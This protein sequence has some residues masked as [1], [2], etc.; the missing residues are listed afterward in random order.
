VSDSLVDVTAFEAKTR[1]SELLRETGAR[2]V[3]R[4]SE[5]GQASGAAGAVRSGRADTRS[6]SRP[7]GVPR[8]PGPRLGA[9]ESTS[10]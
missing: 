1:L 9:G 6:Q 3:V 5:A 2:A 7:Q 4:D 10:V 8:D